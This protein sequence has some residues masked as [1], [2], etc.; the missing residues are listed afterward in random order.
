MY[1]GI[2]W[3]E[4][5]TTENDVQNCGMAGGSRQNYFDKEEG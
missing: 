1:F 5:V 2:A 3:I 4:N